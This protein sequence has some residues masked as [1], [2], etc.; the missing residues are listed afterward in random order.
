MEFINEKV[1]SEIEQHFNE[2]KDN[3][4]II[5]FTQLLN[6]DLCKETGQLLKEVAEISDKIEFVEYNFQTDK[7]KVEEFDIKMVPGFIVK[8]KNGDRHLKF[9]GIPS[10]YEFASLL[11]GIKL[12]SS[13]NHD[14]KDNA[15]ERIKKINKPVHLQVF[16]TPTCPYCPSAVI[17]AHTLAYLS[18]NITADMIEASEFP[19]L[20]M[21][22]SVSGVPKTVIN[23]DFNFSGAY[24][25]ND[26]LSEIEKSLN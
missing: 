19:E 17:N 6:C 5:Y 12:I 1:K 4:Q 26:L 14:L 20:S 23:D 9:Y 10:G 8:E 22:Y 2:L 11:H 15:L 24:P 3:I 18:D 25:I 16:V 13:G 21:K 7:E